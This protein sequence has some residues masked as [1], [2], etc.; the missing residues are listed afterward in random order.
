MVDPATLTQRDVVVATFAPKRTDDL[1]PCALSVVG[2]RGEWFVWWEIMPDDGGPYVGQLA[3]GSTALQPPC[4]WVPWE[5]LADVELPTDTA[6]ASPF[7]VHPL[8][9]S[10]AHGKDP[11]P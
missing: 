8:W 1:K 6:T 11:K 2:W 10:S 5:D 4:V 3:M 9:N 7:N